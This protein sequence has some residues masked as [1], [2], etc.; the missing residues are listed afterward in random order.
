MY[1]FFR[2]L[3]SMCCVF[4]DLTTCTDSRPR[5]P[6]SARGFATSRVVASRP[7]EANIISAFYNLHAFNSGTFSL[8]QCCVYLDLTTC[9]A[10]RPRPPRSAWGCNLSSGRRCQGRPTSNNGILMS[11]VRAPYFIKL[12]NAIMVPMGAFLQSLY[13]QPCFRPLPTSGYPLV[14]IKSC[15]TVTTHFYSLLLPLSLSRSPLLSLFATLGGRD[16]L[17]LGARGWPHNASS[18]TSRHCLLLNATIAVNRLS[19]LPW[20]R[21]QQ[22]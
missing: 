12:V 20:L 7:G 2:K 16:W 14:L 5:P 1:V 4:F 3:V 22:I 11:A 9:T 8:F 10:S 19:A 13:R 6:R 21:V 15:V 17:A 18:A